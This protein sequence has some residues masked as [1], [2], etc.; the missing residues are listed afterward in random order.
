MA[1]RTYSFKNMMVHL[2]ADSRYATVTDKLKLCVLHSTVCLGHTQ[3]ALHTACFTF[4]HRPCAFHTWQCVVP[5]IG[6][7][8]PVT[9]ITDPTT[10]IQ[11]QGPGCPTFS[12]DTWPTCAPGTRPDFDPQRY[13]E[14][15]EDLKND[16]RTALAEIEAHEK[17]LGDVAKPGSV[18]EAE[19]LEDQLKGALKDVEALKAE[20]RA[21]K[22]G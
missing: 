5:S 9:I 16:L 21:K 18:E 17:T 20:L 3:C 2:T 14:Q 12:Y 7:C 15:V 8:G 22:K 4:T 13:I 10:P 1:D 6:G 11:N 19:R